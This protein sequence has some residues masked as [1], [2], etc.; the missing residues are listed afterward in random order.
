MSRLVDRFRGFCGSR[1]PRAAAGL[2]AVG[3][4]LDISCTKREVAEQSRSSLVSEDVDYRS[5]V[6]GRHGLPYPW[7]KD[8][9]SLIWNSRH[10]LT[11]SRT[12][13][14]AYIVLD[15]KC[16]TNKHPKGVVAEDD[17]GD[18]ETDNVSLMWLDGGR[19]CMF[20]VMFECKEDDGSGT[21]SGPAIVLSLG[22]KSWVDAG[23]YDGQWDKRVSGATSN[24]EYFAKGQWLP[25]VASTNGHNIVVFQGRP[26][27]VSFAETNVVLTP[28]GDQR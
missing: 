20:T 24:V 7:M 2:I 22:D 28:L 1:V 18:G 23:R 5:F 14:A 16:A 4:L 26:Y 6:E 25:S 17:N 13:A 3:S 11:C 12:N 8:A 9:R 15:A 10:L 19:M 21:P 27:T